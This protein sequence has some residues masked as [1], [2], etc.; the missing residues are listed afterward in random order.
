MRTDSLEIH[1]AN[2]QR[3]PYPI[4]IWVVMPIARPFWHTEIGTPGD[5]RSICAPPADTWRETWRA[6]VPPLS[7]K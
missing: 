6:C 2:R 4:C 3:R 1:G 7:M 5:N